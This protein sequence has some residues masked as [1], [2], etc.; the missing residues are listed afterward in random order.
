[1]AARPRFPRVGEAVHRQRLGNLVADAHD[2]VQRRHRLLKDQRDARAAHLTHLGLGQAQ[3][4]P[5]LEHHTAADDAA[6]RLNEAKNGKGGNGFAAARLADQS[7]SF[8]RS[9]VKTDLV[10]GGNPRARPI[11]D[12]GQILDVQQRRHVTRRPGIRRI[13]GAACR[14]FRRQW[15]VARQPQ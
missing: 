11:E 8:A 7:Q 10:N 4:V 1:M 2:R 13:P 14:R 5:P 3:Q 6:G 15:R 12:N 9:N